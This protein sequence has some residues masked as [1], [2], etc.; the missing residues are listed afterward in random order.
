MKPKLQT[1]ELAVVENM[2]RKELKPFEEKVEEKF[3]SVKEEIWQFKKESAKNFSKVSETLV[4]IELRLSWKNTLYKILGTTV[5][6][7]VPIFIFW[8]TQ[9]YSK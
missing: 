7:S 3:S 1:Q 8:I 6:I 2:I 9:L 5:A 4:S